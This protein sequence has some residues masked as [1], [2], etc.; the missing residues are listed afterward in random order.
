MKGGKARGRRNMPLLAELSLVRSRP[1]A[2]LG[3][4][5]LGERRTSRYESEGTVAAAMELW[6]ATGSR[7]VRRATLGGELMR[8]LGGVAK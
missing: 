2:G 6:L 1:R 7:A 8:G 3:A 4:I 5:F